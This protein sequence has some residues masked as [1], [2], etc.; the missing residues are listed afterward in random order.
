LLLYWETSDNNVTKRLAYVID[1]GIRKLNNDRMTLLST[2]QS[3][4]LVELDDCRAASEHRSVPTAAQSTLWHQRWQVWPC[5]R[6]CRASRLQAH[7]PLAS[8]C[9][10]LVGQH[11][12]QQTPQQIHDKSK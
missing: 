2:D 12:V 6:D 5:K 8:I 9:C 10:R 4:Q 3:S 7:T 1:V 11:D